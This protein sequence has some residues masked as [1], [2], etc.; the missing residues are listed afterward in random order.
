MNELKCPARMHG[1]I[2][3][4]HFCIFTGGGPS[5]LCVRMLERYHLE[6]A[7][8]LVDQSPV[9]DSLEIALPEGG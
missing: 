1:R 4:C 5:N 9:I 2:A 7:S 8:P 6:C 3:V